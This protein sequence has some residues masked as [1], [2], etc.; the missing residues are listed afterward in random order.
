MEFLYLFVDQGWLPQDRA[1]HLTNSLL[2]LIL[3]QYIHITLAIH[4]ERDLSANKVGSWRLYRFIGMSTTST[5]ILLIII[6]FILNIN[7]IYYQFTD[8]V[9]FGSTLAKNVDLYYIGIA[10]LLS[11]AIPVIL[12]PWFTNGKMHR[13]RFF[14]AL[15]GGS[16]ALGK[17]MQFF[18]S[19]IEC[20]IA[21]LD[22]MIQVMFLLS[23]VFIYIGVSHKRTLFY[24]ES[25]EKLDV[26][27]EG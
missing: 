15:G 25:T 26:G 11:A 5:S 22:S 19:A 12:W 20:N 14:L 10:F 7:P 17:A 16:Q 3:T 13:D 23:V 27:C 1:A 4:Y 2:I 21:I 18:R 6:G 8:Y 24:L 9:L